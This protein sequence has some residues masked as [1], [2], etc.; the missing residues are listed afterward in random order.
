MLDAVRVVVHT[1]PLIVRPREAAVT[2]ERA[3]VLVILIALALFIIER[4][5]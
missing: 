2:V 4:I 1:H 5:A 3:L